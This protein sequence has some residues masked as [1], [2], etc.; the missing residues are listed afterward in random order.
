VLRGPR[1]AA[2]PQH[3]V[4]TRIRIAYVPP[5]AA[6]TSRSPPCGS[7]YGKTRAGYALG[8]AWWHT[9]RIAGSKV[10]RCAQ[11]FARGECDELSSILRALRVCPSPSHL[12]ECWLSDDSWV[13]DL[14]MK[15]ILEQ[16]RARIL[17]D[18]LWPFLDAGTFSSTP[19]LRLRRANVFHLRSVLDSYH[20]G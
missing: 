17:C 5:S 9:R 7:V 13:F 16:C 6:C 2:W 4:L 20:S 10:Q 12:S 19:A 14:N 8:Y 11:P 18:D 3:H 15:V 1:S